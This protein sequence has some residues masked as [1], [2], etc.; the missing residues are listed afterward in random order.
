MSLATA[1]GLWQVLTIRTGPQLLLHLNRHLGS[2]AA[3]AAAVSSSRAESRLL[4][5]DD[6]AE[7]LEPE[8]QRRCLE[9]MRSLPAFPRAKSLTPSRREKQS[10]AVLILLCQEE[11]T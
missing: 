1:C 4:T 7:L 8:A 2:S 11:G 3:A 10:S 5:A 9:K 6:Y